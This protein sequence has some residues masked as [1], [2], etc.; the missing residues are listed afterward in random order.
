MADF[1]PARAASLEDLAACLNHIYLLADRPAYRA[2]EHDSARAGGL[3]PGTRLQR[4]RLARSTIS[5]VLLGR[6][7]PGKAF[8]LTFVDACGIDLAAD[9]RWAQAWDRLAPQYQQVPD[10]RETEKLRQENQELRVENQEFRKQNQELLQVVKTLQQAYAEL[11][12][13]RAGAKNR[14][15]SAEHELRRLQ[16]KRH[17]PVARGRAQELDELYEPADEELGPGR[18]PDA[19]HA[20]PGQSGYRI[21]DEFLQ[22]VAH[23]EPGARADSGIG[24][25]FQKGARA[26]RSVEDLV[27]DRT[28]RDTDQ[29]ADRPAVTDGATCNSCG[30]PVLKGDVSCRECG[31]TV[32]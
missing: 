8:L 11:E 9:T 6:K 10:P 1:D 12:Q 17:S 18:A 19:P 3:L 16:G 31:A 27:R 23:Q 13:L 4:A 15:A 30:G 26:R 28:R 14:A 2:L 21:S 24:S 29:P 25:F 5:D 20:H 7:F 22:H 32:G